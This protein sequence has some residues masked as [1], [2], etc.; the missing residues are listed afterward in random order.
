MDMQM[1]AAA[2]PTVATLGISI[3]PIDAVQQQLQT[4]GGGAASANTDQT[5][6][7]ISTSTAIVKPGTNLNQAAQIATKLLENLYNYVT[8]FGVQDLPANA[9]PLGTLVD[10]G[11]LPVKAFHT[12]YESLSR[13]LAND[14]NYLSSEKTA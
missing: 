12:W 8:S 1:D 6:E 2:T 3:E 5:M 7:T 14:P 13:K 9:I 10:R 11:Y 4:L